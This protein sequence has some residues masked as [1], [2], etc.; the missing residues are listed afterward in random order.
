M[1]LFLLAL[2]GILVAFAIVDSAGAIITTGA[3]V[4]NQYS[5][6]LAGNHAGAGVAYF[7]YGTVPGVYTFRTPNQSVNGAFTYMVKGWPLIGGRTY[8]FTAVDAEDN[9]VGTA[10]SFSLTPIT[11][12][13]TATFGNTFTGF[14]QNLNNVTEGGKNLTEPYANVFGGGSFGLAIFVGLFYSFIMIGF[15]IYSEDVILPTMLGFLIAGG[16]YAGLPPEFQAIAYALTVIAIGGI[17]STIIK[18]WRR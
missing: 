2:I 17:I 5:V 10:T 1:K 4:N 16:V 8:Y 6:T 11:P 13:P 15:L 14:S 12:L 3:T 9:T 7:K 18:G